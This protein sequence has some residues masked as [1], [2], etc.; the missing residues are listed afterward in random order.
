[1]RKFYMGNK[2]DEESFLDELDNF[3]CQ[4]AVA[5]FF[6]QHPNGLTLQNYAPPKEWISW[7]QWSTYFSQSSPIPNRWEFLWRYYTKPAGLETDESTQIPPELKVLIDDARRLQLVR[8]WTLDATAQTSDLSP[9]PVSR[10]VNSPIHGMSPK[11][12]HEVACTVEYVRNLLGRLSKAGTSVCH[13][14]DVGAGQVRMLPILSL[15]QFD[16]RQSTC[17]SINIFGA[18]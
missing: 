16:L 4:P 9:T 8:R 11:K 3:L 12:A 17:S 2:I 18:A 6:S 5:E 14:V 7:W 15:L 13:V 1:M 10:P